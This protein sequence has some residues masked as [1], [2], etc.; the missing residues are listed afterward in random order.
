MK[1]HLE[2]E[3]LAQLKRKK[4]KLFPRNFAD[5]KIKFFFPATLFVCCVYRA[6]FRD[7]IRRQIEPVKK[8]QRRLWVGRR[9]VEQGGVEDDIKNKENDMCALFKFY[10]AF[11]CSAHLMPYLYL[12]FTNILY[13]TNRN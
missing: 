8:V 5:E 11:I 9:N 7:G 3:N 1:L 10:A 6:V 2:L 4:K 13:D 12:F